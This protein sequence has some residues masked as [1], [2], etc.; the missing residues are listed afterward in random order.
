[1]ADQP[2][3]PNPSAQ[4]AP[5][6]P[7]QQPAPAA[8][9]AAPQAAPA[10]VA[11]TEPSVAQQLQGPLLSLRTAPEGEHVLVVRVSPEHLGPVT[12]HATVSHGDLSVQLFTASTDARDALRTMLTDLRRDLGAGAAG[13]ATTL[14]LGTGD[15][16]AQD[17]RGQQAA[18]TWLGA[19]SG[20]A[21][22]GA[23]RD[24]RPGWT[25]GARPADDTPTDRRIPSPGSALLDVL[26]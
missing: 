3:A 17:G 12:V 18:T 8:P 5:V 1:V 16:P 22:G 24:D 2:A 13:S 23:A 6:A 20:G 15:A 19:G 4:L 21:G 7:A 26:A 14:A 11:T 10:L 9:V 25:A